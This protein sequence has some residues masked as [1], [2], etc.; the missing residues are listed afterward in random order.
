MFPQSVSLIPYKVQRK[1]LKIVS[2]D[3]APTALGSNPRLKAQV[4]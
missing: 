3:V 2:G 1:V 4:V